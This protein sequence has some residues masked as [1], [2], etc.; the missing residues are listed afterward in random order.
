MK[1]KQIFNFEALKRGIVK[2]G[3]RNWIILG[4]LVLIAG[5]VCLNWVL[6]AGG[7]DG[8]SY[9]SAGGMSSGSLTNDGLT[10][11]TAVSGEDEGD[12]AYFA[13]TQVSRQ[14]ARDEA[15]EVLRGVVDSAEAQETVKGQALS[16][17]TRIALD[18]ELEAN[19]ETLITS[20][21]FEQCVA[22]V[23]GSSANIIVQ[24]DGLLPNEIA[25]INEIVYEQAGILPANVKI[26]ERGN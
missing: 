18:M 5:A 17:I 12:A 26:I 20:K 8:F 7:D 23:N 24:S 25:Q 15:M 22:V 2:V 16:D 21:G 9:D 6:F 13:A 19:I 3:R 1:L 14:R 10:D 11:G 4:A